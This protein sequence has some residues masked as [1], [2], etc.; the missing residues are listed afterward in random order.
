MLV[1]EYLYDTKN[2]KVR[3]YIKKEPQFLKKHPMDGGEYDILKWLPS[4]VNKQ[5]YSRDDLIG[6]IIIQLITIHEII[7]LKNG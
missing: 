7:I 5:K 2:N 1:D 4:L 6:V 3:Q